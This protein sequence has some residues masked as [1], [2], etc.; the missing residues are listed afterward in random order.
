M[1]KS[2]AVLLVQ[3]SWGSSRAHEQL[4]SPTRVPNPPEKV[5]T[6]RLNIAHVIGIALLL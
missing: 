1:S 3:D 5:P 6:K 4:V 2:W